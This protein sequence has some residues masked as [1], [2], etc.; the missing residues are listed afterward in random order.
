MGGVAAG[1]RCKQAEWKGRWTTAGLFP[2]FLLT[3][4]GRREQNGSPEGEPSLPGPAGPWDL[5]TDTSK[6][7]LGLGATSSSSENQQVY[8]IHRNEEA[9]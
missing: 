6:A 8:Y 3:S 5:M 7:K 1:N 2:D 9:G 4:K